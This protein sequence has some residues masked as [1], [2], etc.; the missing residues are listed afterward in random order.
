M[1]HACISSHLG[2]RLSDVVSLAE[3][4]T[5]AHHGARG[6][7]E[8]GIQ[9]VDVVRQV[10]RAVGPERLEGAPH[11]LPDSDSI[12]ILHGAHEHSLGAEFPENPALAVVQVPEAYV[13]HLRRRRRRRRR[14]RRAGERPSAKNS[15]RASR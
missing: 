15:R 1:R 6:G 3:R 13:R 14:E 4:E 9:G 10:Q 11:N 8:G 12:H 2:E 5:A 7:G